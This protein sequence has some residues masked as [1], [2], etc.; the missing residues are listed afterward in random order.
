MSF[1]FLAALHGLQD[2]SS[3]KIEPQ[4]KEVK[5]QSPNHQTAKEFSQLVFLK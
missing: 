4:A 1:I 5:A 2:L 3:P